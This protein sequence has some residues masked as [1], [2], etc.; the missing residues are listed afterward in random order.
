MAPHLQAGSQSREEA[1]GRQQGRGHLEGW[2]LP[3]ATVLQSLLELS[4]SGTAQTCSAF[5]RMG[6]R[7]EVKFS[8]QT[9]NLPARGSLLAVLS[10]ALPLC[11]STAQEDVRNLHLPPWL[12]H[13]LPKPCHLRKSSPAPRPGPQGWELQLPV[14]LWTSPGFG[15][16]TAPCP[17]STL[18]HQCHGTQR[19]TVLTVLPSQPLCLPL[20]PL[21][22]A[23]TCPCC[24][25]GWALA[26][27]YW[28]HT[29][30]SSL[31]SLLSSSFPSLCL[32]LSLSL[33]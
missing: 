25:G 18:C 22:S 27:L 23:L 2:H 29:V 33:G 3:G 16:S 13:R 20:L 11:A 12:Q 24:W 5:L 19:G 15:D 31:P 30:R 8:P 28:L 9:S 1:E 4:S 17:S 26:A 14:L 6:G 10:P 7:G 32:C 21:P